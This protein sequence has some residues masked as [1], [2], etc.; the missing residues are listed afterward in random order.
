MSATAR[1]ALIACL[2]SSSI[3][4]VAGHAVAGGTICCGPPIGTGTVSASIEKLVN[5][6]A[7]DAAPGVIVPVGSL[8]TF[9]YLVTNTG[10]GSFD[11]VVQDDNG[12]P[13]LLGDDFSPTL[14]IGD[15][16][17][18]PGD[19]WTYSATQTALPGLHTNIGSAGLL[20]GVF[21]SPGTV[22]FAALASDPASYTGVPGPAALTLVALALPYVLVRA[23]R[24]SPRHERRSACPRAPDGASAHRCAPRCGAPAPGS[25]ATESRRRPDP[26]ARSRRR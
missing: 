21:G 13:G 17:F 22:S 24:A 9:R 6:D 5:G 20:I 25:S 11:V 4:G 15:G 3:L 19:T 1:A 26:A 2:L 23:R 12:T 16:V 10:T 7:A 14:V 18:D 8:V